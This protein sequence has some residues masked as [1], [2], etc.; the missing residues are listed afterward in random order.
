MTVLRRVLTWAAALWA[1]IGIVLVL[2]PGWLVQTILD[3]PGMPDDAWLR[4]A[5]L[6]AIALAA[7]MVLVAHRIEELWWWSWTFVFLELGAAVVFL[8]NA[9]VGVPD[10]AP[11]WPW[12]LLG[13]VNG[14]IGATELVAIAQI[15]TER[16][17]V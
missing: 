9:I 7:Q 15:G 3:Q 16:P 5:G 13:A 8:A 1:A 4:V 11:A 12:W 2:V 14:A 10:G 6:T 17:A